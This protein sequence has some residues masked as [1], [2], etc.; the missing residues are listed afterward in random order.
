MKNIIRIVVLTI[1][2]AFL[3]T[4]FLSAQ[5][6]NHNHKDDKNK[7]S[8]K[9]KEMKKID[10]NKDGVV[11]ECPMKCEAPKDEPGECSKCGMELKK[12]L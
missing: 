5:E 9:M 4:T 10:K 12:Y 2:V 1:V 3:S 7:V 11:Y 6:H 8:E